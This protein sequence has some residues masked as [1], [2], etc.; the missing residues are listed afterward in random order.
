MREPKTIQRISGN[1]QGAV[2]RSF[3]KEI[4]FNR[5]LYIMTL[6]GILFF[7]VFN[8]MPLAGLYFAFVRYSPIAPYFGLGSEFVGLRNFQFFFS[9]RDW[10]KILTN[11][12]FLN[13][14]FISIGL[15][16]QMILAIS[17]NEM[18]SK[19]IKKITQSFMFLPNFISWTVVSV[20]SIA[21]FATNE[22]LLNKIVVFFGRERINFY[23]TAS[24]WPVL[25]VILRLWK[26]A[27][28]GTVIY[29][30]TIAG[31]D[32][33]IYEAATIDGASRFKK[34]IHITAPL[35]KTT[36]AMLLIMSVGGIFYGD[37]GMIFALV[38]DNP[39]LRATTDIIDTYVYRA[40]RVRNDI[41]MSSAIGLFQSAIGFVMVVV[42]NAV[43]RWLDPDSALF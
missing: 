13:F 41:G 40:L 43:V 15:L 33:E 17:L 39:M 11:T 29:L 20:L 35:L 18:T 30:S 2:G 34:I 3:F 5:Y 9:S 28:F 26:T 36:T 22:G 19:L 7:V 14:L 31:I 32:Q 24:I 12:L 4:I 21:M 27:G 1:K 6:P 23:Q 10:A 37:F 25:L 16:V 8:Y 42:A 38:G